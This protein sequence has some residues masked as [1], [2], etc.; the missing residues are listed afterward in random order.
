M[1]PLEEN[2]FGIHGK[3]KIV[4]LRLLRNETECCDASST[5]HEHECVG[6]ERRLWKGAVW[7]RCGTEGGEVV[8]CVG[9]QEGR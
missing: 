9:S 2:G 5:T 4:M 6:R 3:K 8:E 7:A 1:K